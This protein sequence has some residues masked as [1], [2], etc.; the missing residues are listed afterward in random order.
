[1]NVF[2]TITTLIKS[3]IKYLIKWHITKFNTWLHI[4]I[5][6]LK[7]RKVTIG[8][9]HFYLLYDSMIIIFKQSITK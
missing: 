4:L 5:L 6:I 7:L 9:M 2:K 1:M 8:Y 3:D